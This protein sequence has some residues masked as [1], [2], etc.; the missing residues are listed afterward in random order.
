MS[1]NLFLWNIVIFYPEEK[2]KSIIIFTFTEYI[3]GSSRV[4]DPDSHSA[5][6][7][8][9]WNFAQLIKVTPLSWQT[10]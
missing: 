4:N 7:V 3:C 1:E 2:Q 9:I 8:T 6:N 10:I 5:L